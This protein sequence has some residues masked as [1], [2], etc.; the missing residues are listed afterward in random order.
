MGRLSMPT[1]VQGN[2]PA[3]VLEIAQLIL[4]KTAR[5][6]N[7]MDEDQWLSLSFALVMKLRSIGQFELWH[8]FFS[9]VAYKL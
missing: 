2:N 9:P 1:Q 4:E 7:T 8:G 3:T 5:H 6:P